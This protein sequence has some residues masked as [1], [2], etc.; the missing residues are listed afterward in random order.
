MG[1]ET[2]YLFTIKNNRRGVNDI[3]GGENRKKK[4]K[5]KK[6]KMLDIFEAEKRTSFFHVQNR[7]TFRLLGYLQG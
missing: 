3:G 6:K 4:R 7:S 2:L 5:E 1:V